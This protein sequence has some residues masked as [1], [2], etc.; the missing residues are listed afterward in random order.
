MLVAGC[1]LRVASYGIRVVGCVEN[2][3]ISLTD[4]KGGHIIGTFNPYGV[5]VLFTYLLTVTKVTAYYLLVPT[6][7]Y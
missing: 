6:G 2:C 7:H 4:K 3:A 5:F 1:W